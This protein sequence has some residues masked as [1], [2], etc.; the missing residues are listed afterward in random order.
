M[1]LSRQE[2]GPTSLKSAAQAN[3]NPKPRSPMVPHLKLASHAALQSRRKR[4]L[5]ASQN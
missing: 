4:L 5:R 2:D 3:G 1:G